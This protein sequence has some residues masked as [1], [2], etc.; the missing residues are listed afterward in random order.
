[1]FRWIMDR[2]GGW[3]AVS[4]L[5]VALF[6]ALNLAASRVVGL[7]ADLTEDKLYSLSEGTR[8]I[9]AE[10]EKPA[11]LTLYYSDAL[12]TTAPVYGNYALRVKDMLRVIESTSRG[13]VSLSIKDPKPFS[14]VEDKAV[15]TARPYIVLTSHLPETGAGRA[16]LDAALDLGY[17]S[18]VICVYSPD[19]VARLARL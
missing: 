10:L 8:N 3:I 15:A 18:D 9:V 13:K 16:M 11:D 2:K 4:I 6:V 19:D 5:A 14:E 7:R 17:I 1:M 12:G